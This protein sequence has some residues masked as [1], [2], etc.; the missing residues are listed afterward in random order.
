MDELEDVMEDAQ[1]RLEFP[2]CNPIDGTLLASED[3]SF[4][5]SK[6]KVLLHDVSVH[7]D[8]K[9]R[10]GIM[11]ANGA[12]KSTL[13]KVLMN[14]L[15]PLEGKVHRNP[16]G[17]V[18]CFAQHHVDQL[19]MSSSPL[20][21]MDETFPGN[22]AQLLR[23]H[24]ARFGVSTELQSRRIG[25]L[26]SGQKSR[27]AF[28]VSCWTQPHVIIMDEPTNWIDMDTIEALI[29]AIHNFVGAVLVISHDQYFLRNVATEYWALSNNRIKI[30][31]SFD[32]CKKFSY[33]AL[34]KKT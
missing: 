32:E 34:V 29:L 27:V 20:A 7:V 1:F 15:E 5:Y 14:Q 31:D 25:D 24:L 9:S 12:G 6:E 19:T 13:V 3:I 26:S 33:N 21:L 2:P 4:G 11:G 10:I 8:M 23:S 17:R 22:P 18:T 16:H 28:A 30:F